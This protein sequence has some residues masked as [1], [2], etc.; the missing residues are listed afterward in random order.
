VPPSAVI[1]FV[2]DREEVP[3][4]VAFGDQRL[5]KSRGIRIGIVNPL[6]AIGRALLAGQFGRRRGR[7]QRDLVLLLGE[8]LH[9]ERHTRVRHV[10]DDVDTVDVKP[11]ADDRVG[12]IGL[13]LVVGGNEFNR[14]I[15][16]LAAGIF[17]RHFRRLYRAE[18]RLVGI[19]TRHIAEHAD[20]DRP[21]QRLRLRGG[22]AKQDGACQ[23]SQSLDLLLLIFHRTPSHQ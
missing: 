23:D 14:L 15:A 5:G 17:D 12:H 10:G 4:L 22:R 8:R 11:V 9:G 19:R 13:V 21:I 1:A 2:V 18:A 6:D 7:E 16:D 20:L 3:A